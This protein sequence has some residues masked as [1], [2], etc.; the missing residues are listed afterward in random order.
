[1]VSIVLVRRRHKAKNIQLEFF[2]NISTN[3]TTTIIIIIIVVV[4]FV[5]VVVVVVVVV[6]V[7]NVKNIF[8]KISKIFFQKCKKNIF[9]K[10]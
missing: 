2:F 9:S 5:V 1:M 8:S 7:K 4:V 10:M 3:L 6:I